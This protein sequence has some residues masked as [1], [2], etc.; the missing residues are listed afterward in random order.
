MAILFIN[1][2]ESLK[3]LLYIISFYFT[4]NVHCAPLKKYS[5]WRLQVELI[6]A[7]LSL[8]QNEFDSC[9]WIVSVNPGKSVTIWESNHSSGVYKEHYL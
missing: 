5:C 7:R 1:S 2:K 6:Q 9:K 8:N 3:T 4:I